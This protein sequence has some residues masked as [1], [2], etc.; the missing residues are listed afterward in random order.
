MYFERPDLSDHKR[1]E[2]AATSSEIVV[3]PSS[4][5]QPSC[6]QTNPYCFA[7]P[8]STIVGLNC[9][10]TCPVPLP[11]ASSSC[12][13]FML[14]SSATSPKT[15]CLPSSQEVTTVVMKNWEPLLGKVL[16]APKSPKPNRTSDGK[17]KTRSCSVMSQRSKWEVGGRL[18]Q[19]TCLDQ[20]LPWTVGQVWS[21]FP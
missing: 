17:L 6:G 8:Q 15:T 3:Y 7:A 2:V 18:A 12:T 21:A 1:V 14:E 20:R 9:S 19:R 13:T 10:F 4:L 11:V 5:A 16:S